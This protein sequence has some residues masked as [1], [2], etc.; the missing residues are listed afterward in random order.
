MLIEL[1]SSQLMALKDLV[2]EHLRC[3]NRTEVY[4]D[5]TRDVE[6]TPEELLVALVNQ[7][8]V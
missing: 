5:V 8:P 1:T 4:V 3:P 7:N 2:A 6:T